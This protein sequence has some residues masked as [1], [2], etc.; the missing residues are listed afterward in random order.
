MVSLLFIST[1][2]SINA[3]ELPQKKSTNQLTP[4][5]EVSTAAPLTPEQKAL[6]KTLQGFFGKNLNMAKEVRDTFKISDMRKVLAEKL[7]TDKQLKNKILSIAKSLDFIST[8]NNENN[9]TAGSWNLD[10]NFILLG[11]DKGILRLWEIAKKNDIIQ[12]TLK[13]EV[14]VSSTPIDVIA[15]NHNPQF[16]D[17]AVSV[18]TSNQATGSDILLWNFKDKTNKSILPVATISHTAQIYSIAWTHD[19]NYLLA[20]DNQG[21][22][23]AWDFRNKQ[24]PSPQPIATIRANNGLPIYSLSIN[25]NN[26]VRTSSHGVLDYFDFSNITNPQHI[27][28]ITLPNRNVMYYENTNTIHWNKAGD[29]AYTGDHEGSF[30][31]PNANGN[32]TKLKN[33]HNSYIVSVQ[34]ILN[35]KYLLS[36]SWDHTIKLWDTTTINNPNVQPIESIQLDQGLTPSQIHI[37]P[38]NKYFIVI[39]QSNPRVLLYEIDES[40]KLWL[41]NKAGIGHYFLLKE[42]IDYDHKKTKKPFPI[43]EM[44]SDLFKSLPKKLQTT[45]IDNGLVKIQ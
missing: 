12:R 32:F 28:T 15:W 33:K 35:D 4:N 18:A 3:A 7:W 21:N 45:L 27:N 39:L 25:A 37:S 38:D 34:S 10:S 5:E 23:T 43:P 29:T 31:V 13:N 42:I 2:L 16:S 9:V 17:Y 11:D 36:G 26:K 22:I 41:E 40:I 44:L 1:A 8:I 19:G 30:I 24:N 20:G 6:I 14:M